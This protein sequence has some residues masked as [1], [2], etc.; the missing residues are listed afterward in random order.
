MLMSGLMIFNAHPELYWGKYGANHERPW[1]EI[2]ST[3]DSGFL[4]VGLMQVPTTGV[5]GVSG[6]EQRAFPALVTIPSSY[7]LAAARKWH[8]AF[9]WLLV[10]PGLLYWLWSIAARHLQRDLAPTLDELRPSSI[11]R[12]IKNHARLLPR[13]RGGAPLQRSPEAELFRRAIRV[14]ATDGV[15][16]ADDVAGRR[17]GMAVAAGAVR[18]PPVGAVNP[19]H[20][21]DTASRLY[22]RA[23]CDGCARRSAQ[24]AALDCNRLVPAAARV[25][26]MSIR[27]SRR[28]LI[29]TL[30]ASAGT[31]VLSDCD[32]INGSP[33]VQRVLGFGQE[34]T[35]RAQR[36]MTARTALAP[37][38][39]AADMS[40]V[41]RTNGNTM[42]NDD[43]YRAHAAK[44]FAGWKLVV[45]GQVR[46]P[47]DLSLDQIRR[48]PT[49][50]QITRH[51]CVEG[52]SAIGKWTGVP[53]K[54]LL[55]GA[56]VKPNARY[57]VFIAPTISTARLIMRASI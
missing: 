13:G 21:R 12:D 3:G 9:A 31:L 44:R 8:L 28:R 22:L 16:G 10:V 57:V 15:D 2:G 17:C 40:P 55:D 11:W 46:R 1:L 47:L 20:L 43:A 4:R 27:L 32:R 53:L 26:R 25:E 48:M 29:G 7:N 39:C 52:W 35:M 49:R 14:G 34:L 5:L 36:I 24:R 19:F 6:G 37:E 30:G 18:R 50:T 41:F 42:P 23:R 45:D 56:G 38:F 33:G 51:D 54:L